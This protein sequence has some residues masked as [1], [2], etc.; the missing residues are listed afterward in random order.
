MLQGG[1]GRD[2]SPFDAG[3][4]MDIDI[5]RQ[6]SARSLSGQL[7]MA[8]THSGPLPIVTSGGRAQSA[9]HCC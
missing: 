7:E 9:F 3:A 6:L 4:N 5:K 8:R 2:G 1:G